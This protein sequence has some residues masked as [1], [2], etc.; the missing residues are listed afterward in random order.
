MRKQRAMLDVPF[1]TCL[2]PLPLKLKLAFVGVSTQSFCGSVLGACDAGMTN[3]R[4]TTIGHE[5]RVDYSRP[6]MIITMCTLRETTR[7][8]K[9]QKEKAWRFSPSRLF[10]RRKWTHSLS[11]HPHVKPGLFWLF[12]DDWCLISQISCATTQVWMNSLGFSFR[13]VSCA[14]RIL[15]RHSTSQRWLGSHLYIIILILVLSSA[16][17]LENHRKRPYLRANDPS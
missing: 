13:Q 7:H 14:T 3:Q 11:H 8:G 15:M 17:Y 2:L 1:F 5:A 6:G 4:R 12:D 16:L 9:F 10:C